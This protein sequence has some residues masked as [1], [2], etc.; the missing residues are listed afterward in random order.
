MKKTISLFIAAIIITLCAFSLVSCSEIIK[1]DT[2]QLDLN[3]ASAN[4]KKAGY[5]VNRE[6]DKDTTVPP[7]VDEIFSAT[8]SHYDDEYEEYLT[9]V[10]F[11][12]EDSAKKYFELIVDVN[13]KQLKVYE[14]EI[15]WIE[16]VL[17]TYEYDL[18]AKEIVDYKEELEALRESHEYLKHH[19]CYGIKDCVVWE[20]T[21][22]A[23]RSSKG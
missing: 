18:S 4:L 17:G 13:N 10:V 3:A 9:V 22:L 20:G 15:N 14:K 19:L 8:L 21:A 6:V 5:T 12:D 23:V 16:H 11:R 1:G 7:G 2:P